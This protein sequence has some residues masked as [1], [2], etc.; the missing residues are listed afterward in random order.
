M[1]ILLT[2]C[3]LAS[4]ESSGTRVTLEETW[5][6]FELERSVGF[7]RR[8]CR[9]LSPGV[10]RENVGVLGESIVISKEGKVKLGG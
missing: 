7:R 3:R 6:Q 10:T 9:D 8:Q 5:N 2:A 4:K 1:S